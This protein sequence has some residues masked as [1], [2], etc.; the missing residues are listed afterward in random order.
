MSYVLH[1][2]PPAFGVPN[3][4]PFAT[5][6]HS[7][8]QLAGVPF[9]AAPANPTAGPR[10][11]I[12][13]L[14]CPDGRVI[15]DTRNIRR[16][17]EQHANL[18]LAASPSDTLVRRLVEDSLYWAVVYFRWQHHAAEIRDGFFAEVPSLLRPLVF[19]LVRR[20]VLRTLWGQGLGR[21][22]EAEILDVV[23]EDL[24]AL[25]HAMGDGP[26]LGGDA[27]CEADLSVHGLLDQ[28]LPSV[29]D[30]PLTRAVRARPGLVDY[31]Q[32]VDARVRS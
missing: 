11:K 3:A 28:I 6:A 12:P 7:L 22:P 19:G 18:K 20:Q 9:T 15:A 30:D 2:A 29:F 27:I 25:E 21:R 8:L 13:F 24:D 4:S 16:H 32:R 10:N 23:E 31:H 1:I 26:F 14:T 5:K 17:L